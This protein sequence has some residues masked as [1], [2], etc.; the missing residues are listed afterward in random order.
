MERNPYSPPQAGVADVKNAEDAP[1]GKRPAWLWVVLVLYAIAAIFMGSR[2]IASFH[3]L[4][5]LPAAELRFYR[6]SGLPR[7]TGSFLSGIFSLMVV[8]QLFRLKR[9]AAY[10][11]TASLAV[12]VFSWCCVVAGLEASEHTELVSFLAGCAVE[13]LMVGYVWHL[14]RKG[15]LK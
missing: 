15:V 4:I 12:S 5:P 2:V 13:L 6:I 1:P 3:G 14:F 8:I 10:F 7:A 9:G 11:I